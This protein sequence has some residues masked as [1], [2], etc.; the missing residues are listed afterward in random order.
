MGETEV[1]DEYPVFRTKVTVE[2]EFDHFGTTDPK[3]GIENIVKLRLQC[4]AV[5]KVTVVKAETN[6][7]VH[8]QPSEEFRS[9]QC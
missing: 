3:M 9:I 5:K 4:P 7:V 6:H 1:K 8:G 2:V